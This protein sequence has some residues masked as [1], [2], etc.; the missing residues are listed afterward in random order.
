MFLTNVI[1][2][3]IRIMTPYLYGSIGGIFAAR[4]GVINIAIEGMMLIG[5]FS[6][7]YGAYVSGS[8][9]IGVLFAIAA[10]A[11][12]GLLLAFMSVHVG[13]N[14]V[15]TGTVINLGAIGLTSFLFTQKFG[16]IAIVQIEKLAIVPIPYLSSLPVL[17][18]IF[19]NNSMLTYLA[20]LLVPITWW[21]FYK[22]SLG[23][24]VRAVGE[25]P[26]A[27]DSLGIRVRVIRYVCPMISGALAAVGGAFISLDLL[28]VFMENMSAGKG[29]IALAAMVLGKRHPVGVVFSSFIFGIAEAIQFRIQTYD[30]IQIPVEFLQ[31]LPYV[32]AVVALAGFIGKSVPP[33]AAG[34]PYFKE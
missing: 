3:A 27:A 21:F 11:V 22:T 30:F 32:A 12:V 5:A 13:T 10:G 33:A 14:Q 29:F 24:N 19:F 25:N 20:F 1:A 18:K 17:G 8:A 26:S 34:K 7:V 2:S 28:S 9:W 4:S 6:G 31:M 16:K 23:L 15:V